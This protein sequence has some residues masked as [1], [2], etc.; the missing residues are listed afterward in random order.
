MIQIIISKRAFQAP[1]S[2]KCHQDLNSV[3]HI[4]KLWPA[5]RHKHQ[6]EFVTD[7]TDVTSGFI[8]FLTKENLPTSP[9]FII[10]DVEFEKYLNDLPHPNIKINF[11]TQ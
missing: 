7:I 11:G 8:W 1:T 2:E 4:L 9:P 5:G 6:K 3:A 10:N